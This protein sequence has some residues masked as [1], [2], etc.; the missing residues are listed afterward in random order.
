DDYLRRDASDHDRYATQGMAH[1]VAMGLHSLARVDVL[2]IYQAVCR[3]C[4]GGSSAAVLLVARARHHRVPGWFFRYRLRYWFCFTLA[5]SLAAKGAGAR[6]LWSDSQAT[7]LSE[8]AGPDGLPRGSGDTSGS[9]P[10][11]RAGSYL[12]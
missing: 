12:G 5:A 10:R 6:L 1:P 2:W 9:W 4:A 3:I 8:E 11:H 7:A